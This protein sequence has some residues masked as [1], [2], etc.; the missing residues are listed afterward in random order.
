MLIARY[1]YHPFSN[2]GK[3]TEPWPQE[4]SDNIVTQ[5]T[6]DPVCWMTLPI[7]KI[8]YT[9]E[10]TTTKNLLIH[11]E[12]KTAC[13]SFFLLR[14]VARND[15]PLLNTDLCSATGDSMILF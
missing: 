13:S 1:C 8:C 6:P 14:R 7:H 2:A 3:P 4:P 15:C 9:I 5:G 11:C 10:Q 12:M